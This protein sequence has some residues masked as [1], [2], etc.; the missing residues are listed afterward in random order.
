MRPT[1]VALTAIAQLFLSVYNHKQLTMR[2][3]AITGLTRYT[4]PA[5]DTI[6]EVI[7]AVAVISLVLAGA[8]KITSLNI[9]AIRDSNEHI[10]ALQ[11]LQGQAELLRYAASHGLLTSGELDGRPFCL[12]PSGHQALSCLFPSGNSSTGLYRLSIQ[13]QACLGVSGCDTTT[14]DLSAQWPALN[15]GTDTVYL[16]YKVAIVSS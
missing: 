12:D 16:S 15:G 7:I 8:F 9:T 10:E 11:L 13:K 6:V 2:M 5:G 3:W 14:F 1:W 4:Q